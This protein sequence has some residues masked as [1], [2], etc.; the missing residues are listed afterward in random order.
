MIKSLDDA[1][2]RLQTLIRNNFYALTIDDKNFRYIYLRSPPRRRKRA[3]SSDSD[4]S[5]VRSKRRKQSSSP[6]PTH[7]HRKGGENKEAN[8]PKIQ[9]SIKME[10]KSEVF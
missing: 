5:P 2:Y 8:N 9:E 1:N 4:H 7:H 10:P 6:P 3:S